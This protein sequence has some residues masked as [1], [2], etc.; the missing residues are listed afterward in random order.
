MPAAVAMASAP[1]EQAVD[2]V[3]RGPKMPSVWATTTPTVESGMPSQRESRRRG[4]T[5]A[6]HRR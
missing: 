3:A 4:S 1:D 5:P 2:T 6:R